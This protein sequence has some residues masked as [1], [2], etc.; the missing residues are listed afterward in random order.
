MPPLSPPG[1][2]GFL[3]CF[4]WAAAFRPG[5]P[6]P[7]RSS[8]RPRAP[9]W[10]LWARRAGGKHAEALP[11]ADAAR[12]SRGSGLLFASGPRPAP[13]KSA[14][15][16]R[17]GGAAAGEHLRAAWGTFEPTHPPTE[18][19]PALRARPLTGALNHKLLLLGDGDGKGQLPPKGGCRAAAGGTPIKGR[20]AGL[21]HK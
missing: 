17:T 12:R 21:D 5:R 6:K 18:V 3:L 14:K 19:T 9:V 2:A 13:Q 8:Q 4:G 11:A 15:R 7:R 10:G 16:K 1:K 20:W